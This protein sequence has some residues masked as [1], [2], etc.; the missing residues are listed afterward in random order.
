MES[1]T[2]CRLGGGRRLTDTACI[3][4]DRE[5]SAALDTATVVNHLNRQR[6]SILVWACL[7]RGSLR[8]VRAI[9]LTWPTAQNDCLLGVSA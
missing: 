4:L 8:T 7:E 5:T 6:Q 1:E 3:W 2:H 9:G